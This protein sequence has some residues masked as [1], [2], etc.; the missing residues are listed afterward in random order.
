MQC[1]VRIGSSSRRASRTT[2][3]NLY[4]DYGEKKLSVEGLR[5]AALFAKESLMAISNDLE[6][7]ADTRM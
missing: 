2:V 7:P 4:S 6:D 5:A 1:Y 3:L